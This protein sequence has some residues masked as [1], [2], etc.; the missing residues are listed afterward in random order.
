[1][2]VVEAIR[3]GI[4][5][6]LGLAIMASAVIAVYYVLNDVER[7]PR[8]DVAEIDAPTVPVSPSVPG[9][10][11]SID[12]ANNA[13]VK[14]GDV[15]FQIDPEP[16]RLRLEQARAELRAAES[17]VA[18]G[19]RNIATEQSNAGI[20]DKQIA[21][22]RINADQA[23]QTLRRLEPLLPKGFVTA[24]QVDEARTLAHDARVSLQ[25]AIE[26]SL[27]ANTIVGTLDTRKALR[28]VAQAT[29]GLAQRELDNTTV[30]APFDGKVVGLNMAVGKFVLPAE[31]LFTLINTDEWETVAFFRETDLTAIRIG[32]K[33]DVFVMTDPSRTIR[34]EVSGIG[35]GVRSEESATIL[36]IPIVSNSLNWVRVAKRFPVY[37]R[38]ENPPEDLMR[39]GASALV[40]VG[41]APG[42]ADALQAGE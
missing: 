18:Q 38:L 13:A 3:R 17:E 39:V 4:A 14:K 5:L 33:A 10:I 1:M 36:G 34:G 9:R 29:V 30:R 22:A 12:V 15:L 42:K 2:K 26:Q 8:T 20:A 27:G 41:Q 11:I 32:A 23:Q 16:Y 24:Q 25:Q 7:S 19:G 40:I 21:R 37:V 28:D 6:L 35:W 31:T